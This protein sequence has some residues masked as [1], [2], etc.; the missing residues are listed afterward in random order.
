MREGSYHGGAHSGGG[1][2]GGRAYSFV[3]CLT[4]SHL[5]IDHASLSRQGVVN[6]V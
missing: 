4:S 6:M 3:A 2:G 1:G 5:T